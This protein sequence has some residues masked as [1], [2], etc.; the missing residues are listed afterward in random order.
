MYAIYRVEAKKI[1]VNMRRIVEADES[2]TFYRMLLEMINCIY[3]FEQVWN[4]SGINHE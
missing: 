3:V 2:Q 4:F 1:R